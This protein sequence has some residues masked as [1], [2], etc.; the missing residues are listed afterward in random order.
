MKIIIGTSSLN[1]PITEDYEKAKSC[2][3][4][5]SFKGIGLH[6]CAGFCTKY[7]KKLNGGYTSGYRE[8]AKNCDSF[9]CDPKF[10]VNE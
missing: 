6:A 2:Q 4:C 1:G 8:A 7:N 10:L 3:F 9:N 5:T